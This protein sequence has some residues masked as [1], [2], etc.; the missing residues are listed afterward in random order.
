[1]PKFKLTIA[2]DGTGY[3]GWQSQ[4]S[5][6]GVCNQLD[7]ALARL[8]GD[9]L[10]PVASSSRTDAGVHAWGLAAHA[11]IPAP[12]FRMAETHLALALNACLPDD[13]RV[14]SAVQVGSS[15]HARFDAVSKQYRYQI[16]NH[17]VMNPLLRGQSWHVPQP[18]DQESMAIAAEKFIG[19]HDFRAF[20]SNRSG[21]LGDSHRTLTRCDIRHRGPSLTVILQGSGFLYKMCRAIVGTLVAIGRN[22][23][24]AAEV[25]ELLAPADRAAAGMNAPAHGLVLW[26]VLYPAVGQAPD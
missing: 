7:A 13:I 6:R 5:G 8:F 4:A 10:P 26:K 19:T 14:R 21:V 23:E 20:T 17:P 15:F 11:E 22:P 24:N 16:W 1:M 3:E 25:K 2:F 9:N 12:R 18:L